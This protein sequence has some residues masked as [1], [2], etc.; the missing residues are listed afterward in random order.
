MCFEI[1]MVSEES[2]RG[3]WIV[4]FSPWWMWIRLL[5]SVAPK[6]NMLCLYQTNI[7]LRTSIPLPLH[8]STCC[9]CHTLPDCILNLQEGMVSHFLIITC[10]NRLICLKVVSAMFGWRPVTFC[11]YLKQDPKQ[12]EPARP[13]L[14]CFMHPAK[15]SWT[16]RKKTTTPTPGQWLV[17]I[18]FISVLSGCFSTMFL[19]TISEHRLQRRV[20]LMACLWGG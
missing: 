3:R 7:L 2:G 19:C 10:W 12:T 1:L 16:Q 9:P 6:M 18:L 8:I 14:P 15:L 4:L 5:A 20:F 17:G 13:S 11:W